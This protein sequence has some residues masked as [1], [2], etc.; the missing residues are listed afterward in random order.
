MAA[1]ITFGDFVSNAGAFAEDQVSASDTV[2]GV[3][4]TITVT[5][6][7]PYPSEPD[8]Q[9]FFNSTGGGTGIVNQE[10]LDFQ[11]QGGINTAGTPSPNPLDLEDI[12]T[13]SFDTSGVL[14]TFEIG[15]FAN[16]TNDITVTNQTTSA[17]VTG[18][19]TTGAVGFTNNT[20]TFSGGGLSFASGDILTVT[21]D[22]TR[23]GLAQSSPNYGYRLR[24]ITI[25][26]VAIPEPSSLA[27][28][29]VGAISLTFGG[30]RRR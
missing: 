12:F 9:D 19:V 13:V 7:N 25:E 22:T 16:S 20:V 30:R 15:Q 10:G 14:Q 27:L 5:S 26:P 29:G 1:P 6:D 21:Q 23:T 2:D 3:T 4:L 24:A 8:V 11:V 17:S 28:L 18:S